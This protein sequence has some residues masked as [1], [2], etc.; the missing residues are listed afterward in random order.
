LVAVSIPWPCTNVAYEA[1]IE[2][3]LMQA[4][5]TL[6]ITHIAFGDLFLED[7][8]AY[9]EQQLRGTGVTPLFPLWG[10]PTA[11]LAQEMVQA[12]LRAVLTCV[13]PRHLPG[14]FAGRT[15]DAD[16]L[17]DLPVGVDPCG[18]KGE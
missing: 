15:F 7:V 11:A 5:E 13:D 3:A 16:L 10:L 1:A 12:G 9:R 8:R 4:R 6:G 17:A 2:T 18:E 14:S